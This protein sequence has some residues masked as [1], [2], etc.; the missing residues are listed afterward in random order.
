M[1]SRPETELKPGTIFAMR[2][3]GTF[4]AFYA[5]GTFY[6][7][8]RAPQDADNSAGSAPQGVATARTIGAS[9]FASCMSARTT[10]CPPQMPDIQLQTCP[11]RQNNRSVTGLW[12]GV[13]IRRV[14]PLRRGRGGD[15]PTTHRLRSRTL[16]TKW[17]QAL[18]ICL[19]KRPPGC[20]YKTCH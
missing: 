5:F 4:Y 16:A 18:R 7:F 15:S 10:Q 1:A 20:C 11:Y 13:H 8:M 12:R 6:A 17:A 9:V 3:P 19:P 2:E 14:R